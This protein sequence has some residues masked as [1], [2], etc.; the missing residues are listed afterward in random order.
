ML[1]FAHIIIHHCISNDNGSLQLSAAQSFPASRYTR[2]RYGPE[3]ESDWLPR[4]V[5]NNDSRLEVTLGDFIAEGRIGVAYTARV[6]VATDPD[7]QDIP[8]LTGKDVVVKFAKPQFARSLAREAWFYECLEEAQGTAVA[9]CYGFFT[10]PLDPS[11]HTDVIPWKQIE[12]EYQPV[13]SN[14]MDALGLPSEDVL[15]DDV[16]TGYFNYGQQFYL[17]SPWYSWRPS[18]ATAAVLVLE[19]LGERYPFKEP[20]DFQEEYRAD[21]TKVL[22]DVGVTGVFHGDVTYYN[23]L[24]APENARICPRHG[25]PHQWRVID[26]DR[27]TRFDLN[28]P[29]VRAPN[30]RVFSETQAERAFDLSSFWGPWEEE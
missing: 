29:V 21:L 6:N 8:D 25:H 27:S 23:T 3:L 30:D 14:Q 24:R 12:L 9:R 2:T 1:S 28:P 16:N 17:A 7:G 18:Q 5:P 26:F 19:K 11:K 20:P 13:N 15:P 22:Q 10:T 4:P